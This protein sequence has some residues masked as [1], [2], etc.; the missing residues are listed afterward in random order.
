MT[1]EKKIA[2]GMVV[3]TVGPHGKPNAHTYRIGLGRVVSLHTETN[4]ADGIKKPFAFVQFFDG[5]RGSWPVEQLK[6]AMK[7][8]AYL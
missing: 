2:A 8:S 1:S 5:K 4:G 6:P 3:E 7:F